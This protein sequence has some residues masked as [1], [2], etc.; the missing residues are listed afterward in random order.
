MTTHNTAY[1]LVTHLY[2]QQ[3]FFEHTFG[4]GPRTHGVLDHIAKE[5]RE[6]AVQPDDLEEWIDVIPLALGGAW[7]AGY[8]PEAIAAAL[9]A[10][11]AK[12][13]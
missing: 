6:I 13:E 3:A 8:T 10:K 7:R 5:L 11:Q 12:N 1:D 2:R 4:P 9:A